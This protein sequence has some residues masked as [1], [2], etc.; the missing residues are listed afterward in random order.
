MEIKIST[1]QI[2][3]VLHVLSWILFVGLCIQAG[4]FIFNAFFTL[5]INPGEAKFFWDG[6]DLSGLYSHDSGYFFVVAFIMSLVASM[7][8]LLFYLIIKILYE[9][10]LDMSQPFSNEVKRFIFNISYLTLGIG[11]FSYWGVKYAEWFVQQGVKM[12]DIESLHLGGA[13]VWLFMSVTLFVVAH[14][15]KRGVEIQSENELTI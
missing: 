4:G 7:K 11:L 9:K 1:P 6:A 2:L 13:D 3:N 12:P 14:I 15:F 10:K 5:T 8:A